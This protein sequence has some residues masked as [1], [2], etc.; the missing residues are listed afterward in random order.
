M[1]MC[2]R[3][4]FRS[5]MQPQLKPFVKGQFVCVCVSI[6]CLDI[7]VCVYVCVCVCVCVCVYIYIYIY[8]Y[9][10]CVCE[11]GLRIIT[12]PNLRSFVQG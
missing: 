11:R 2:E 4:V 12:L 10:V 6:S 9:C 7:R 8:I 1:C 5:I 3:V